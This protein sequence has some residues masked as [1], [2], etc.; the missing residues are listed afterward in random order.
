MLCICGPPGEARACEIKKL[1]MEKQGKE[2]LCI[3]HPKN[4]LFGSAKDIFLDD[5]DSLTSARFLK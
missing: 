3:H 4:R 1:E 2:F 5:F